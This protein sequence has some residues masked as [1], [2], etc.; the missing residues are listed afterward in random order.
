[1]GAGR[2]HEASF[3]TRG[4]WAVDAVR[5]R[6]IAFLSSV[7]TGKPTVH[8]SVNNLSVLIQTTPVKLSGKHTHA[9]IYTN[10]YTHN[11][12]QTYTYMHTNTHRNIHIHKNTSPSTQMRTYI[13][14]HTCVCTLTH[15]VMEH[16]LR[17]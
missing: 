11:H 5:K 13:H 14:I 17:F 3:L 8:G 12:T 16:L 6:V 4:L 1:M 9:H 7:G 10:T 15:T 2:T